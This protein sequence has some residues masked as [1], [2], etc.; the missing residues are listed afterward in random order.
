[1]DVLSWLAQ[2]KGGV[3]ERVVG[4]NCGYVTILGNG[5]A[6]LTA[7]RAALRAGALE[8]NLIHEVLREETPLDLKELEVAE[9]EGVNV[10]YLTRPVQVNEKQGRV[11]SVVVCELAV[12]GMDGTGRKRLEVVPERVRTI[13]SDLVVVAIQFEPDLK[14]FE[15]VGG[16][17]ATSA[18]GICVEP[19]TLSLPGDGVF[20]AGSIMSCT[21]SIVEVIGLGKRAAASIHSYLTGGKFRF[22]IPCSRPLQNIEPVEIT[23]EAENYPRAEPGILIPEALEMHGK[24]SILTLSED[25]AIK[26]ARRCLRC[27]L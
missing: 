9:G 8:V 11:D 25:M 7:A 14:R 2:V 16:I 26:E 19:T 13:K 3:G 18:G 6:A 1:M 12:K 24:E 17:Y 10:H 27:D 20:A 4:G 22:K 23:G 5:R 15:E 21:N